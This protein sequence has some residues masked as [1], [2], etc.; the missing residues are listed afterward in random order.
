MD[1]FT[2]NTATASICRT[3]E[4]SKGRREFK[5]PKTERSRRAVALPAI[6]VAALRKHRAEQAR[7]RLKLGARY[8]TDDLVCC[9][10]DGRPSHPHTVTQEF[11]DVIRKAALPRV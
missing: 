6:S 8:N 4:E 5:H 2:F 7:L 10:M 3:L 1:D 11:S 9:R